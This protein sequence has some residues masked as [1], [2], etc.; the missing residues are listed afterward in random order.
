M[1][2]TFAPMKLEASSALE[3]LLLSGGSALG[4][5]KERIIEDLNDGYDLITAKNN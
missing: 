5:I 3:K 1:H 4:I 2:H